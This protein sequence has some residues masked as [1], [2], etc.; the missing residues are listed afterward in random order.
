MRECDN[1]GELCAEEDFDICYLC[2]DEVCPDCG[3]GGVHDECD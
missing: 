2:G 1:C 3:E